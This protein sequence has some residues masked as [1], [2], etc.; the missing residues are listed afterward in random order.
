[1][2]A[3][4]LLYGLLGMPSPQPL[5]YFYPSH[6]FLENEISNLDEMILA[7]LKRSW[8]DLIVREKATC[9]GRC[10][11]SRPVSAHLRLLHF[12]LRA[13]GRLRF[14]EIWEQME[15]TQ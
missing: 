2:G 11:Q 6:A 1:M 14:Y 5:L 8:V 12:V 15:G 10:I 13:G 7:A 4:T 3:S 9:V